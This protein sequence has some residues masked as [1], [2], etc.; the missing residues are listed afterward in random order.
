MC[1]LNGSRLGKEFTANAF[2][3]RFNSVPSETLPVAV[4]EIENPVGHSAS[5]DNGENGFS[6]DDSTADNSRQTNRQTGT[7]NE[8]RGR[9]YD[10]FLP[11]I[12][13]LDLFHTGPG[14]D[15]EE[16]AFYRAMQRKK[17]KGRRPKF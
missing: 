17:K 7:G 16:E 8:S 5:Q 1:V 14:F 15:P 10:D 4:P 2:E 13:G 3:Q 9:D 12:P 11:S 6:Y